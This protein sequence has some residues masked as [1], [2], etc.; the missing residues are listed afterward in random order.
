MIGPLVAEIFMFESIK[1][2]T[3]RRTHGRTHGRRLDS[4][5]I[6]SPYVPAAQVS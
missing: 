2:R 3:H 1:V 4:H 6:S 5:P